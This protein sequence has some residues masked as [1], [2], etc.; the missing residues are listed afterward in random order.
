MGAGGSGG[1]GWPGCLEILFE[2][3]P[4]RMTEQTKEVDKLTRGKKAEGKEGGWK[5]KRMNTRN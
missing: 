3:H 5:A 2:G 4:E 1:P